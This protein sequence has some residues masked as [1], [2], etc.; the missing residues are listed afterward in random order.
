VQTCKQAS[1]LVS[2]GQDRKLGLRERIGLRWHLWMCGSCRRFE[3]QLLMLRKALN[4]GDSKGQ[5]MLPPEVR[6]R[7]RRGIREHS[8]GE[9]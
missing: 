7:I 9:H 3:Q 6:E 4:G 1:R 5:A 2:E 8:G